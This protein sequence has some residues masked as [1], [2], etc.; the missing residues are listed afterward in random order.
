MHTLLLNLVGFFF[1]ISKAF[2]KVWYEGLIFKLKSLGV[3]DA[4]LKFIKSFFLTNRFQGVVPNGQTSECLLV[5][6]CAPQGSIL[7][8]LFFLIFI[9][10]LSGNIISTVKLF[11]DD[12]S[13]FSIVH[14]S[15]TSVNELKKD[16]QKISEWA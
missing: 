8:P 5:K 7:G 12:T 16:L 11:E 14:D 1:Y 4:L 6:A 3:S 2:D 9:N 15:N 13:L 10:N